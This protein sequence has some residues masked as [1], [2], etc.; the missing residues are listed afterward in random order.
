[1]LTEKE[2]W[3]EF[4]QSLVYHSHVNFI[5]YIYYKNFNYLQILTEI[6]KVP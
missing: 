1:M 6:F 2:S 5:G 3:G 4:L